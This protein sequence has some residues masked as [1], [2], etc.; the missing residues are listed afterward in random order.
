MGAN[1]TILNHR[2]IDNMSIHIIG[3][4]NTGFQAV[5]A[6]QVSC[7]VYFSNGLISG[8]EDKEARS[9]ISAGATITE[10]LSNAISRKLRTV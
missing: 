1:H 8:Y 7:P 9:H 2:V 4:H 10:T 5:E 3:N 6:K